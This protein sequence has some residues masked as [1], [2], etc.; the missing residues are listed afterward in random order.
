[1]CQVLQDPRQKRFFTSRDIRDLFTLGDEYCGGP[2]TANGPD[3]GAGSG[4]F[5]VGQHVTETARIFGSLGADLEVGSLAAGW[6]AEAQ[7]LPLRA[8]S[9]AVH[10]ASSDQDAGAGGSGGGGGARAEAQPGPGQQGD[11]H[12]GH[13]RH[14]TNMGTAVQGRRRELGGQEESGTADVALPTSQQ[15]PGSAAQPSGA[16]SEHALSRLGSPDA[17]GSEGQVRVKQVAR[18]DDLDLPDLGHWGRRAAVTG[19]TAAGAEVADGEPSTS[20]REREAGRAAAG[21]AQRHGRGGGRG[22]GGAAGARQ[23]S[24]QAP[25]RSTAGSEDA[26]HDDAAVDGGSGGGANDESHILRDLFDGAGEQPLLHEYRS[27]SVVGCWCLALHLLHV[28]GKMQ[29]LCKSEASRCRSCH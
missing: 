12:T 17:A 28:L 3:D 27:R 1:M 6:Q 19:A 8:R 15:G 10:S 14:N 20:G 4:S 26:A 21:R 7:A 23:G 9:A 24:R 18:S 5:G 25:P 29:L 11:A 13:D 16:G 2:R 22:R